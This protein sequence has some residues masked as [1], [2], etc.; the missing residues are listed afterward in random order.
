VA[1]ALGIEP[2]YDLERVGDFQDRAQVGQHEPGLA[3]NQD[4]GPTLP[5]V[6]TWQRRGVFST[7]PRRPIEQAA[8]VAERPQS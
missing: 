1:D 6:Q 8:T 4:D 2:G 5:G 7:D 3:I